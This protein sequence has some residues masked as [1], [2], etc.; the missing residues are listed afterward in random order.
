MLIARSRLGAMIQT[1]QSHC[2]YVLGMMWLSV[3][4]DC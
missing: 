3:P 1:G 2:K 4:V